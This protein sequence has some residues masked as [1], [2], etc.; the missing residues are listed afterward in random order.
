MNNKEIRERFIEANNQIRWVALEETDIVVDY[1]LAL[2]AQRDE[3]IVD[4]LEEEIKDE[5]SLERISALETAVTIILK[6]KE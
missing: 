5:L 1:W 2:I 6:K 3:E 4:A